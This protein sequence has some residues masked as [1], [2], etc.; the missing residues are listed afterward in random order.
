MTDEIKEKFTGKWKMDRSENFDGFMNA[1][2]VN[3]FIRKMA[4]FAKPENDI[5]VEDDGT[6]VIATNSTFMKSEQRF[7][8]DE[9]YVEENPMIK[10]KFKNM[11][12][13]KDGKLRVTPTPAEQVDVPYPDYAEREITEEVNQGG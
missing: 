11:P 1:M 5:K 12:T 9:E 6:I 7:K 3:F 8:L 10:K 4:G 2:G 13:F